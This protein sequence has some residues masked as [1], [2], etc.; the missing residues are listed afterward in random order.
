MVAGDVGVP[1]PRAVGVPVIAPGSPRSSGSASSVS[2]AAEE[3][4]AQAL[5]PAAVGQILLRR[6]GGEAG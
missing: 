2:A 3:L 5:L 4:L 1:V 6:L